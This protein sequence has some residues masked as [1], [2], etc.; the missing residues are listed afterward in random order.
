MNAAITGGGDCFLRHSAHFPDRKEKE[1]NNMN[2]Q[3]GPSPF[4]A[5]AG[6]KRHEL[7]EALAAQGP[8]HPI[9]APS[10]T[11]GWLVTGSEETRALL[12]DPRIVKGG[13]RAT[14]FM[15]TL[16]EET[17]RAVHSHMLNSDPTVHTRLRKLV[18]SAFTRRRVKKLAPR[19]QQM[20][21]EL[22]D[23]SEG[24]EYVDLIT[25]LAYPLP[26]NVICELIGVPEEDRT[27]FRSWTA[28][29]VS[30]GIYNPQDYLRAVTSLLDYSRRL[31]EQKRHA[32]QDDLLSQLI[33]AR[34][35]G[36]GLTED[37]LTSMIF[38]LLI[39]GHET[40]V[41]L[42]GNGVHALLSH[43]DQLELL[44]ER[45]ELLEGAI[46]ELLRYDSPLQT[47]PA[48]RTVQPVEAGGVTIPEGAVVYFALLAANR[49]DSQFPAGA[50]L[51]ITREG[52]A[53][54]A[55]GHG[56]HHCLGAPLA[57]LEALIVFRTLLDRFPDLRLAVPTEDLIRTPSMIMNGLA[58]LPVHLT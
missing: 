5:V 39:A 35:E 3:A 49:D 17:A 15:E 27:V 20:T 31:I 4:A 9:T 23:A 47:T 11:A 38:L 6:N 36:E 37:E 32:P 28:A 2:T 30:P 10:G 56:I 55:F 12:A 43:P 41:N 19:I 16:P 18:T 26:L 52:P 22:L 8:V 51:D 33:S 53:H 29:V 42:I 25:G 14:P 24:S 57:R 54:V 50:G 34:D 48:Y 1:S 40:T 13:W 7:Y 58:A 21:D 46:E 44:R 45:P